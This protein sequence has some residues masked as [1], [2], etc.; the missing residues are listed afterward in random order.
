MQVPADDGVSYKEIEQATRN[1]M[2]YY[3][4]FRR[5]M[6]G[7]ARALEKRSASCPARPTACTPTPCATSCAVTSPATS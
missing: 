6:A 2:N 5:S 3:M 1:V 7:M 4:G